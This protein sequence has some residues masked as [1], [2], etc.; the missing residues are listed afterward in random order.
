M[1]IRR[2][3]SLTALLAMTWARNYIL[4]DPDAAPRERTCEHDETEPHDIEQSSEDDTHM[5][6]TGWCPGPAQEN[7][8][9]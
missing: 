2:K 9:E 6:I 3:D 7:D 1:A 8:H 4:G 5:V